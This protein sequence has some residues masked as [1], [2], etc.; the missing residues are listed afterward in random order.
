MCSTACRPTRITDITTTTTTTRK[1]YLDAVSPGVPALIRG[2]H[3]RVPLLGPTSQKARVTVPF[4]ERRGHAVG[5]FAAGFL[6]RGSLALDLRSGAS[7]L[8]LG[9]SFEEL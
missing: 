8:L 7:W 4:H 2:L 3:V 9:Q 1:L 5:I 6:L